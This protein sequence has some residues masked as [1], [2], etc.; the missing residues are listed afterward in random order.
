MMTARMSV[1]RCPVC[2]ARTEVGDDFCGRCGAD[3]YAASKAPLA[4]GYSFSDMD[5]SNKKRIEKV[6]DVKI[7]VVAFTVQFLSLMVLIFTMPLYLWGLYR[8]A[9][10]PLGGSI[11][12]SANSQYYS[13]T[14]ISDFHS[15]LAWPLGLLIFSLA[16]L[17]LALLIGFVSPGL[18]YFVNFVVFFILVGVLL[19]FMLL[20]SGDICYSLSNTTEQIEGIAVLTS[21]CS[22]GSS[23]ATTLFG[24]SKRVY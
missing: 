13:S 2:G 17:C 10:V 16:L 12:C 19:G 14:A 11:D 20:P 23:M 9:S 7:R 8:T 6:P 22:L 4:P 1:V 24:L 18:A 21:L 3:L 15:A 5:S